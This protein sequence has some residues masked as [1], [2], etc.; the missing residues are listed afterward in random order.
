ML[1]FLLI[2]VSAC[3]GE[4]AVEGEALVTQLVEVT[5]EVPIQIIQE[6]EVTR[7][8]PVDV[9]R[10]VEV[11]REV[12]VEIIQEVEVTREVP[13]DVI[14]EVEVTREVLVEVTR[15]VVEATSAEEQVTEQ[16]VTNI[17]SETAA[18]AT[19]VTVSEQADQ[20]VALA[21]TIS[22]AEQESTQAS[23][24][25]RW[26][27]VA[28]HLGENGCVEA[29]VSGVGESA[30]A[31]FINFAPERDSFYAV[32][33]DW[34]WEELTG[35]CLRLSGTI[36]DYQGRAQLIIEEPASQVHYCGNDQ[37]GPPAFER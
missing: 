8:V 36:S 27:E 21:T 12:P 22:V 37:D 30:N 13:V 2:L 25:W 33:F 23:S 17:T 31:F 28:Q 19:V 29:V 18:L 6:V 14:R 26:E 11:T 32:S 15:L 9:I 5:R 16:V 3:T 34:A 4:K 10:E 35:E 20:P 1:C 7:E 24:C